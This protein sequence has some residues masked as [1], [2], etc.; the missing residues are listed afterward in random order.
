MLHLFETLCI[1]YH[2]HNQH[3]YQNNILGIKTG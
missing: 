2:T 3:A 1:P